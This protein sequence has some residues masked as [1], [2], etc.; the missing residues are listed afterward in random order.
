M[1]WDPFRLDIINN[2]DGSCNLAS[3]RSAVVLNFNF[4]GFYELVKR[5]LD[6]ARN[7]PT[8]GG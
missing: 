1:L 6:G 4:P 8:K 2:G 7:Y 5:L 3:A